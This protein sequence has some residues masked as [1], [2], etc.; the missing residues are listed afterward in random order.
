MQDDRQFPFNINTSKEKRYQDP[1]TVKHG[2]NGQVENINLILLAYPH[3]FNG[4]MT[5]MPVKKKNTMCCAP[6]W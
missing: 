6:I 1:K 5:I 3:K 4:S 2:L